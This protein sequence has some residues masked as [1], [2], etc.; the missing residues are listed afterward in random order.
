MFESVPKGDAIFMKVSLSLSSILTSVLVAVLTVK[1]K[2]KIITLLCYFGYD[3]LV[4]IKNM[5]VCSGY[6]MIGV[7]ITA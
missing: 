1:R 6:F 5:Y 2:K 3:N 4:M 7:M